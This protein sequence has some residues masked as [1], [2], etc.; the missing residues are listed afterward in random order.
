MGIAAGIMIILMGIAHNMY[1]EKKQIP[2]LK[3]RVDDK[4]TIGSTRIMIMQGGFILLAVGVVQLLFSLGVIE[5]TG[6]SRYFPIGIVIINFLVSLFI[7]LFQH[8]EIFKITVPQFIIF[9]III[10][11]MYLSL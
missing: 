9:F 1:G 11:L 4:I 6:V 5:L 2:E 10:I 3:E 7:A 8:R